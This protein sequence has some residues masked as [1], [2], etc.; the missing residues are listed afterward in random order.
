MLSKLRY[1]KVVIMT[2]ADV[3]GSHIRTLLLTF[4][5]RQMNEII[6]R[7][8]LYIAQPPLYKVKKGKR[9]QYI[10]DESEFVDLIV[11][12]G[13]ENLK[14]ISADGVESDSVKLKNQV[15]NFKKI[16]EIEDSYQRAKKD[17]RVV[18]SSAYLLI[19][20]GSL[21]SSDKEQYANSLEKEVRKSYKGLLDIEIIEGS[22]QVKTRQN[23][24][25]RLTILDEGFFA[26]GIFKRL[27]KILLNGN[28][29]GNF[30]WTLTTGE[31]EEGVCRNFSEFLKFIDTRGRKGSTIIRYKGL[32]E[33]NPD[34]LWETTL[35]PENRTLLQVRIEDAIKADEIFSVLMGDE[36]EPRRKF[37]EDNALN[38]RNLDV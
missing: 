20:D 38:I 33:M 10:K 11:S 16:F 34:Q 31:K 22:I 25:S 13:V 9:E 29:S 21:F 1:H 35:D 32:G 36:V 6:A 28:E 12:S 17:F 26:Q 23:G 14:S 27:H 2:D 37:I 7:G 19:K 15:L 24:I 8:N 30:P 3:D 5:F 18:L 4:F